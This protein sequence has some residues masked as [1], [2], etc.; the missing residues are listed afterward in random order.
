[1]LRPK[2]LN[3]SAVIL[4]AAVAAILLARSFRPGSSRSGPSQIEI[5]NDSLVISATQTGRFSRGWSWDLQVD[6]AGKAILRIDSFPNSKTR[7]FT[8]SKQ[9]IDEL[10]KV[11]ARGRFF[12]LADEYGELAVDSSTTT[13][14]VGVG[15]TKKTV[16]LNY[17]MNWVHSD[18]EKLKEPSRA[19]RVLHVIR[20][21]FDD[22]DA[23]DLRKYER[24]AA[25]AAIFIE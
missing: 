11:I 18:P 22:A 10:R 8:V 19:I 24:M 16:V 2:W 17:L 5:E 3:V 13:V 14:T 15:E 23:V 20:G 25:D 6:A 12:E 4:I 1:M 9:Q 21:W 7:Q